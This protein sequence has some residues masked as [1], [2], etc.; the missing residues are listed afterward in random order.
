MEEMASKY[1]FEVLDLYEVFGNQAET[2]SW[3][4]VHPHAGTAA[5]G[6][7]VIYG[8]MVHYEMVK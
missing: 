2:L 7:H 5:Q 6:A 4:S 8:A 1:G 3:D